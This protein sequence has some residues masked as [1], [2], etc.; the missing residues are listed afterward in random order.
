LPDSGCG[1]SLGASILEVPALCVGGVFSYASLLSFLL[2]LFFAINQ[3][4]KLVLI[5]SFFLFLMLVGLEGV[6][7]RSTFGSAEYQGNGAE[8]NYLMRHDILGYA[9]I[10]N[11]TT[12]IKKNV[13][14]E[15]IY[16]VKYTIDASG[17]RI[18]PESSMG[19]NECV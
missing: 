16:S 9:P 10:P 15:V 17:L 11:T 12:A 8:Q 4:S 7:Y 6:F 19:Y 18:S 3:I 5:N 2:L 14:S 1:I 13:A